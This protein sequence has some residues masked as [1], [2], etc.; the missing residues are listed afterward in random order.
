[1]FSPPIIPPNVPSPGL[2]GKIEKRTV[3]DVQPSTNPTTVP[4]AE[5]VTN[6]PDRRTSPEKTVPS[7]NRTVMEFP[8]MVAV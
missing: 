8:L 4:V 5:P 3:P 6:S 7:S 1:M 2:K